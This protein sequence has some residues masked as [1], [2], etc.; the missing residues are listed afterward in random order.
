MQLERLLGSYP[1][2][3]VEPR[4]DTARNYVQLEKL[5]EGTYATVYKV[6]QASLR[7][8]VGQYGCRRSSQDGSRYYILSQVVEQVIYA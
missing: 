3:S 2:L 8:S 4:T 1:A 5:G 6:C 7:T